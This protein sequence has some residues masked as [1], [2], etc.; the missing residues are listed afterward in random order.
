MGEVGRWDQR[1]FERYRGA[2]RASHRRRLLGELIR[3]H[4]PLIE[5]LLAQL[6]GQPGPKSARREL[7]GGM[8]VARAEDLDWEEALN[9][10]RF[11]CGKALAA[12]DPAKGGFAGYLKTKIYY[13]LQCEVERAAVIRVPRDHAPASLEYLDDE[14][15]LARLVRAPNGDDDQEER[16]PYLFGVPARAKTKRTKVAPR[17]SV[18][19]L[20]HLGRRIASELAGK[21]R[22]QFAQT[23]PVPRVRAALRL[24][25]QEVARLC[26]A[27]VLSFRTIER[28]AKG[29][30]VSRRTKAA[31]DRAMHELKIERRPRARRRIIILGASQRACA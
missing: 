27:T 5:T 31:L 29:V 15:H 26:I 6:R 14:E 11:A 8:R 28:W 9:V 3:V 20:E 7:R 21:L 30:P 19:Q 1:L 4:T 22:P 16:D 25:D 2:R 24:Y 10:A 23:R 13:E 17:Q 18:E 12:F